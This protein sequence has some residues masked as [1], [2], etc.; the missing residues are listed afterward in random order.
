[1]IPRD[2]P[3]TC[4]DQLSAGSRTWSQVPG[5]IWAPE[6]G[7]QLASHP[8]R[9][10]VAPGAQAGGSSTGS[11]RPPQPGCPNPLPNGSAWFPL[12]LGD[13]RRGAINRHGAGCLRCSGAVRTGLVKALVL[14][15]GS[16]LPLR[17]PTHHSLGE[18]G[19][20]AGRGPPHPPAAAGLFRA[21]LLDPSRCCLQGHPCPFCLADPQSVPRTLRAAWMMSVS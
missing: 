21:L 14:T 17:T 4:L 9:D 19:L 11:M 3:G 1:M 7:R 8:G 13:G 6:W 10:F 2:E 20:Q 18:E 5:A 12:F 16:R 15:A